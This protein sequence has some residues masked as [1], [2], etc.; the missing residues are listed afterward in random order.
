MADK[1]S[2]ASSDNNK[3]LGVVALAG[4]VISAMLG[5]GVYNLPQN[6]SQ[7]ASAGAILI[8]WVITGIGTCSCKTRRNNRYICI[9]RTWI[10]EVY[11]FFNGM[12][13]LD[14]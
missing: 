5:G 9:W 2:N 12:G 1:S 4:V 14:M 8:A 7:N 3:K 13:I 10:W 6:M 11:R